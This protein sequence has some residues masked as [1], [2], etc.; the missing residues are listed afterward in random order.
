MENRLREI[1]EDFFE[2]KGGR[3]FIG[4]R[5]RKNAFYASPA[6][7]RG[8]SETQDISFGP[9]CPQNLAAH[10][11]VEAAGEGKIGIALKGCD[12]R[13]IVELIK[14]NRI[15][16]KTIYAVGL[17]CEGQID[18]KK[19]TRK[20]PDLGFQSVSEYRDEGDS[21][22]VIIGEKRFSIK[23]S[24]AFFDKCY[25]CRHP[26]NFDFDVTTGAVIPQR[27]DVPAEIMDIGAIESMS[28]S[29]RR[30]FWEN[31]FRQ[32]LRCFACKNVCYGC[33]CRQC[34]FFTKEPRWLKK[35]A[36][37]EENRAYHLIRAMHLAGRCIDCGECERVCPM[38]IPLRL[39]HQKVEKEILAEFH[40]NPPGISTEGEPALQCFD[41]GDRDP[42]KE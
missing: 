37:S 7:I 24:E 32:C 11:P 28:S 9:F 27:F 8:A 35:T 31:Q 12:A 18:L 23:K 6:Y 29:E 40:M 5:R 41:T 38:N 16:R 4:Y 34:I 3:L 21:F 26:E 1:I 15:E 20:F 42:F 33:Y 14:Q 13:A 30:E 39:L 22:S 36:G 19:L 17:P 2:S 25:S 10:N